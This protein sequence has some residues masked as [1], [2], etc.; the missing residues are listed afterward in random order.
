MIIIKGE[1]GS[2]KSTAALRFIEKHKDRSLYIMMEKDSRMSKIL[3]SKGFDYAIYRNGYLLDIKYRILERGGL[4]SNDLKYVVIDCLNLIKD[5]K[6]YID[7]LGDLENIERDFGLEIVLVMNV[8]RMN[9]IKSK[10][11]DFR[12]FGDIMDA[13][14]HRFFRPEE[15]NSALLKES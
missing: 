2:G 15:I 5:H 10:N 8:L 3:Y 13:G 12:Q 7:K 4:M 6:S 1:S 11:K 9:N 14:K